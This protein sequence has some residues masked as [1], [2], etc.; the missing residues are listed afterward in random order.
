MAEWGSAANSS[1]G[2]EQAFIVDNSEAGNMSMLSNAAKTLDQAVLADEAAPDTAQEDPVRNIATR[3]CL[4][5]RRLKV[6]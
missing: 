6:C 1:T 3:A 5:C 2:H 4:S